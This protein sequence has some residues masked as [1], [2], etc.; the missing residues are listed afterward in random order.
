MGKLTKGEKFKPS[1]PPKPKK[2]QNKACGKLFTPV[3]IGQVAC[4]WSCALITINSPENKIK[5]RVSREL[6]KAARA[7]RNKQKDSVKTRAEHLQQAQTIFNSFIRER[8][9]N[10]PC[11]SCG[12]MKQDIQYH[13]GHFKSVG[14]HRELRFNELNCHKQCSRC[15]NYLSGN[16]NAY[17]ENLINKIGLENVE[18]LERQHEPKKYTIDEIKQIKAEY[19]F[20]LKNLKARGE[21]A[22]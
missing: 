13:V 20:K 10:E 16:L 15:N 5:E 21:H 7:E 14:A 12:T 18:L 3:R 6:A 11:I 17:R 8:D 9:K 1:K 4:C 19:R 2:C 22:S